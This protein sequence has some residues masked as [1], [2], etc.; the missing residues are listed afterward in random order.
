VHV[1]GVLK[2]YSRE[3]KCDMLV[4]I[5]GC[6]GGKVRVGGNGGYIPIFMMVSKIILGKIVCHSVSCR[7]SF[8]M[9]TKSFCYVKMC[10]FFLVVQYL[11]DV[12]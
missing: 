12:F 4:N 9:Y 2:V 3:A 11:H 6:G 10:A 5:E 1:V 7:N 8:F